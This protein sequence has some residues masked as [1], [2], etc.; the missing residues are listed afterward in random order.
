MTANQKNAKLVE[1]ANTYYGL[2]LNRETA[3]QLRRIERTL[4]RWHEL[5]CGDGNHYASW[6][7]QRDET[8]GKPYMVT[9]PHKGASYRRAIADREK[10][11]IERLEK[12]ASIHGFC[13]FVQGDPRGCALYI[14]KAPLTG[15]NYTNGLAVG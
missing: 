13:F 7:I 14:D 11:A 1:R 4:H 15:N 2:N 9:Y 12:L 8:T 6:C 5:E 3:N 10:G